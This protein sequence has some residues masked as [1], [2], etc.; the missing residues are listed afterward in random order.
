MSERTRGTEALTQHT[1]VILWP[2]KGNLR[3][4]NCDTCGGGKEWRVQTWR[5]QNT[6][7]VEKLEHGTQ[8]YFIENKGSVQ[9]LVVLWE[10][11][12][13]TIRGEIIVGEVGEKRHREKRLVK[14]ETELIAL[15]R[16]YTVQLT[17]VIKKQMNQTREE[18]NIVTRDE[19]CQQYLLRRKRLYEA[20][21]KGGK[22]LALLGKK[23]QSDSHIRELWTAKGKLIR[24]PKEIMEEMAAQIED[25]Y[26]SCITIPEAEIAGFL[27]DCPLTC[28]SLQKP[29][30]LKEEITKEELSAALGQLQKGKSPGPNGLPVKFY[31]NLGRGRCRT[32][33]R[34]IITQL[35]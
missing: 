33:M 9:S 16:Q 2:Y 5:L 6:K 21:N 17:Q 19:V 32:Y 20:V 22:L 14:L 12:Q 34:H 28:L 26:K 8:Y 35:K 4:S 23:E 24:D 10:G 3:E 7:V 13:A 30:D 11:Y 15:E 27:N 29:V 25:F 31:R 18:Y 1:E